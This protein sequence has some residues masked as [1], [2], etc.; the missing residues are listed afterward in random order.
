MVVK[1]IPSF[2]SKESK[3]LRGEVKIAIDE[4]FILTGRGSYGDHEINPLRYYWRLV[5]GSP[6]PI[7]NVEEDGRTI[8]FVSP[9]TPT[10]IIFELKVV[11]S[12]TGN[13]DAKNI[14]IVVYEHNIHL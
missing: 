1:A 8:K 9:R 11:D 6:P 12:I 5:S 3:F 13:S 4:K 10:E 14:K 2:Y 7:L